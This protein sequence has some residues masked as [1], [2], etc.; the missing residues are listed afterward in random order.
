MINAIT[1]CEVIRILIVYDT[2]PDDNAFITFGSIS[3]PKMI[4]PDIPAGRYRI[5]TAESTILIVY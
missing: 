1:K 5:K 3:A 2:G 4:S